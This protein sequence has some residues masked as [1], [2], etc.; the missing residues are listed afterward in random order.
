MP[1][2]FKNTVNGD[3]LSAIHAAQVAKAPHNYLQ[4][5]SSGIL[6]ST[7]SEGNPYSHIVLRGSDTSTNFH[8]DSILS[9][10]ELLQK[11]QIETKILVDCAHGNSN[12][13]AS[14]QKQVFQSVLSSYIQYPDLIAG[15]ML[16]SSNTL[17]LTD[18]CLSFDDTEKLVTMAHNKILEIRQK[19]PLY[20]SV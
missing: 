6:Q 13:V 19:R 17:S 5:N 9:S 20:Q 18:P 15:M 3:I 12:K 8:L 14:R 11:S 1:I 4:V 10:I 2:G 7:H 16:E